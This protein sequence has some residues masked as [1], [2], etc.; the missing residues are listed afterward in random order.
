MKVQSLAH[1]AILLFSIFIMWLWSSDPNLVIY[2][3]QL[4]GV[5]SLVYFAIKFF[6][7]DIDHKYSDILSMAILNSICLLLIFSTGGI[8]SPLFFLLDFL[9]IAIALLMDPSQA[10]VAS[11]VIAGLFFWQNFETLNTEKIINVASLLLMAPVAVLFSKT[12]IDNL[13]SKGR[14][15][16]LEDVIREEETESLLWISTQ[17]KPSLSTVLNATTDIVMY[18]NSKG[19]DLLLPAQLHTKLKAIQTDLITLY[20]ST[21][22]LETSISETADKLKLEQESDN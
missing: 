10:A 4:T 16:V 1:T 12:Y 6:L 22:N 11:V 19:R 17:A 3:L 21:S 18:F 2:N 8:T 5:L 15:E 7:R 13:K 20:T 9:L 14:I